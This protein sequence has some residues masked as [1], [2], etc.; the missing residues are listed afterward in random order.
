[1]QATAETRDSMDGLQS[2]CYRECVKINKL[3][4]KNEFECAAVE[5]KLGDG[6][7]IIVAVYRPPSGNV[8]IFLDSMEKLLTNILAENKKNVFAGDFNKQK[9]T[10]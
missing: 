8:N 2:M 4:I 9:Q 6:S 1:M 7:I 3:S 10:F 5:C